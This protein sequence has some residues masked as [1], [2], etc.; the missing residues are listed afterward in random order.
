[1]N[2]DDGDDNGDDKEKEDG[3]TDDNALSGSLFD[4]LKFYLIMMHRYCR[5]AS[6]NKVNITYG[7]RAL[8]INIK[9]WSLKYIRIGGKYEN[10]LDIMSQ[11]VSSL[12][13]NTII[14]LVVHSLNTKVLFLVLTS[15]AW[16]GLI[17]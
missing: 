9:L 11:V 15:Y 4:G 6:D 8:Y 10:M 14:I 7:I 2:H 3:N 1:M 5:E 16:D 13:V 12:E 17:Y